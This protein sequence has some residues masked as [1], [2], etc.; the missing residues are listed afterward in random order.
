MTTWTTIVPGT[1]AWAAITPASLIHRAY[2]TSNYAYQ[3]S[4]L[5]AYQ[6]ETVLDIWTPESDPTAETWTQ[7]T[8]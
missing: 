1:A 4:G 5:F 8:P 6:G 2:Q 3:G 7:V